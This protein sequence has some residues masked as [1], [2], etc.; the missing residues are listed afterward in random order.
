[1][2]PKAVIIDIDGT[3]ANSPQPSKEHFINGDICWET[4]IAATQYSPV[5]EWCYELVAAMANLGYRIVYLTARSGGSFSRGITTKWLKEN[6]PVPDFDLYM[7]DV[8]DIRHDQEQKKDVL[9]SEILPRYDVVFVV[10]D[11]K[12]N[13]DMFREFGIPSL[14]CADY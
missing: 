7:R 13:V 1:M 10:D 11:K 12:A 4:W 2:R 9:V 5:H 6:S 3:L 8:T 14:H